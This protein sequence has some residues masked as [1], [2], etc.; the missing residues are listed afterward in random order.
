M[1]YYIIIRGPLGCGKSTICKA[2]SKQL[3]A[4]VFS[5]D[6]VLAENNLEEDKEDGYISQKS[7]KTA[8]K[9]I[10]PKAQKSLDAKTPVIIEG[11]F[12]WKSQIKDLESSINFPHYIFTLKAPLSICIERD[13]NRSKPHGKIAAEVVYNKSTEFEYGIVVDVEKSLDDCVKEIRSHLP[14]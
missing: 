8:N 7:F 2:L 12:Y 9:I 4:K 3:D 11:N 10:V 1:S 6:K 5:V 14:K 13:Q